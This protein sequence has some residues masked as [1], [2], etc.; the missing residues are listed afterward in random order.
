MWLQ[1][2]ATSTRDRLGLQAA[3][4]A[5]DA[6]A[7][8]A[9]PLE[10]ESAALRDPAGRA[11]RT[12]QLEAATEEATRLRGA[13]SR[14]QQVMSDAVADVTNDLADDLR[15]RFRALLTAAEESVDQLDPATA[16]V[17]F[18]PEFRRKVTET[19]SAHQLAVHERLLG[20]ARRVEAVFS[21]E[22]AALDELISAAGIQSNEAEGT[23]IAVK[24]LKKAGVG[25]KAM[26]AVR[27]SYSGAVLTGFVTG[28]LG[29]TLAAPVALAAGAAVGYR[30]IREDSKRQLAQRQAL[31]KAAMRQYVD[32]VASALSKETRDTVAAYAASVARSLHRAGRR[33]APLCRGLA[34]R[35]EEGGGAR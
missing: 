24:E 35:G 7:H 4:A 6:C 10:Q 9:A 18:E 27:A 33:A 29:L 34:R 1:R 2:V 22:E 13:A 31:A 15:S 23:P 14:W 17:E 19:A 8:L 32:D 3:D 12:A 26:G 11:E 30:G 21:E 16:W 5:V 28:V 20:C 25:A